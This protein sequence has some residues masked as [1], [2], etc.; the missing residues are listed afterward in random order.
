M[1]MMVVTAKAVPMVEQLVALKDVQ[2]VNLIGLLT[3]LNAVIAH[4]MSLVL[5]V[6]ILKAFMA[7]IVQ[8]VAAQVMVTQFVVTDL[9]MV[10][11]PMKHAQKIVTLLA[12]V[13]LAI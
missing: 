13:M 9:V 5:T 4:G 8:D 2:I 12:N 7:G 3:D 10:M 1:I 6:L 11:K